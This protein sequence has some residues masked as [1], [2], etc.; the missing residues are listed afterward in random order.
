MEGIKRAQRW[1]LAV[2]L[3]SG[4]C[5]SAPPEA[6]AARE[7]DYAE[8]AVT[9]IDGGVRV[10]AA[11]L[12]EEESERVYGVPLASKSIQPVWV[13][14]ENHEDRAYYLLF[15]G[16]DPD[17][18]A[19]SEAAEIFA[20]TPRQLAELV[21]RF[22]ELGFRN[23]VLA[24]TT[25]AGFVL[26]HFDA[27]GKLVQLDL[28]GSGDVK[29]FSILA[30][31]P[32]WRAD[33]QATGV[34][35]QGSSASDR[36]VDFNDDAAFLAALA[37][38]PC[39]VTNKKGDR[40]GD[41]LNLVIVGGVEDAFPAL[42]RRGWRPTEQKWFGSVAK[43]ATSALS[44]DRYANAPV[45]DLYLYARAQDFALQKARDNVHQRNHLRLWL[46]PM[47]YR[48]KQVWV[49]QISRDIGSRLT[50][51]SPTLTTHKIDP[52]V[53]EARNA[54]IEDMAYSQNLTKVGAADGV[55]AAS[56]SQPRENLTTDP[57][58]TDGRRL[59]LVFDRK[60]TSMADIEFFPGMQIA[61]P[62]GEAP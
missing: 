19:A 41:P 11:V 28:V 48:G 44:G 7:L 10:S 51:H 60:P 15:P 49:G 45:S 6:T 8:R 50:I 30:G 20:T 43:T 47:R 22:R 54:L 37:R 23:P 52:D 61:R 18:F 1:M 4:G 62:V 17:F 42:V 59:I 13:R 27:G 56:R 58:Y 31:V 5:A 12:S 33:Y 2:V 21:R 29:T 57:Y 53:D 55:G 32:G 3:S 25:V 16:L 40:N 26:T 39:C 14:I 46:S 24:K 35:R 38:L 36:V 34:F 9:R